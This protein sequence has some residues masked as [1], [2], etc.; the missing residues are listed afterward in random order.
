MADPEAADLSARLKRINTLT[1]QLS[2]ALAGSLEA[3]A[4]V[5]RI[6][7][8]IRTARRLLAIPD[9]TSANV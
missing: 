4:L 2:R 9:K 1:E 3:R 7:S 5:D 8:E 6:D